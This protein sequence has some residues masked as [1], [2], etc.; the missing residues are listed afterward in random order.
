MLLM[1]DQM[2]GDY[3]DRFQQQWTRGLHRLMTEGAR[4]PHA[5]YPYLGTVT[6]AR[7]ASVSTGAM[8]AVHGM[9]LN[10]WW[11]REARRQVTC[12]EDAGASIVSYGKPVK[13]RGESAR[14]LWV[15]TLADELRA[16]LSPAAHVITFSPKARSTIT[17]GGQHPDVVAWFDESVDR[18]LKQ[19]R[20][21][22]PALLQV[23]SSMPPRVLDTLVENFE[24]EEDIVMRT[25][26]RLDFS[27]W[28][29]LH[30]LPLAHLKDQPHTQRTLWDLT[31][32]DADAPLHTGA[33]N[34]VVH[35][36]QRPKK[37][38]LPAT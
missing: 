26:H 18:T 2:R 19:L 16:Q 4:F 5:D 32:A 36:V 17:L 38:A 7:H 21:A 31:T 29:A 13:A 10:A 3:A 37:R 11:D 9:I 28:M 27:N 22:P 33:G 35:A 14:R 1:V 12:T 24:V 15:S 34:H 6:C 23:E 25:A 30:R 8:P 20:H